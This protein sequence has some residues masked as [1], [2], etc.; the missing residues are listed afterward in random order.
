M[1]Y[2]NNSKFKLAAVAFSVLMTLAINGSMLL[3][4]D[5][6]AQTGVAQI[7]LPTVTVYGRQA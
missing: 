4:F 1:L 6:M 3:R 2:A 7:T 5:A